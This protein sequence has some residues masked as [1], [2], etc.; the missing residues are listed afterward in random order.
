MNPKDLAAL[1]RVP[2]HLYPSTGLIYGAMAC[3]DGARKYGP[4]NWRA[5][6]ISHLGYT[7]AVERHLL[8]IR[9]GEQRAADSGLFHWAHINATSAIV[10]DAMECEMLINDLPPLGP[11]PRL[12]KE[13]SD[14]IKRSQERE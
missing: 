10:L 1:T 12:L 8:A 13:L 14:A 6:P 4:Y 2:L 3:L 5:T 11:A 7:G 9:D